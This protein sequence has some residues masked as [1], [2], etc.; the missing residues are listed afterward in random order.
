MELQ[1]RDI[2]NVRLIHVA[3]RVDLTT[4]Q[5]FQDLLL[6]KLS[7]CSGE[8]QK[9]LLDLSGVHYMS[10]AGLRVLLLASRQCQQQQG[11]FVLAALPAFLQDV[12]R[13][14][15]FNDL[16]QVFATVPAALEHLSPTAAS[17]YS[18]AK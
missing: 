2:A 4:A 5:S 15:H 14:T 18:G 3:G 1:T 9:A 13:V 6:P 11:E 7:D 17:L 12:F 16:F 10:S 8:S